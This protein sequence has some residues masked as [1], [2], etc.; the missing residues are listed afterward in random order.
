MGQIREQTITLKAKTGRTET[1]D[2]LKRIVY[3]TQ[4]WKSVVNMGFYN[5]FAKL[6]FNEIILSKMQKTL[7]KWGFWDFSEKQSKNPKDR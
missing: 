6:C 3:T 4:K 2:T 5:Y 1:K 7:E